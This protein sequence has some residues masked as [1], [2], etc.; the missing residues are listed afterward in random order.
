MMDIHLT[1][2]R[3]IIH[4][5]PAHE[6]DAPNYRKLR[7][8]ALRNHPEAFSSDYNKNETFPSSYWEKRLQTIG[9]KEMIYFA[10]HNQSLIGMCG[11]YQGESPKT[12]HTGILWGVYVRSDWR[13]Y[14]IAQEMVNS[15]LLWGRTKGIFVVTLAVI[16]TN[17]SAIHFYHRCGFKVY[18]I[19]PQAIFC[20]D[21]MYDELLMVKIHDCKKI[22]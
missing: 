19:Q 9:E 7:L 10:A 11:L 20:N 13:G 18:G 4:I 6:R 15:C 17:T 2:T 12:Q 1:T 5:R 16:T 8:D 14:H 22:S 21:V 3:G